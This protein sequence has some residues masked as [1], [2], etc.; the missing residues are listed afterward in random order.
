MRYSLDVY[1]ERDSL[2]EVLGRVA[3]LAAAHANQNRFDAGD[4]NDG[5]QQM[6]AP[7]LLPDGSAKIE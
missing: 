3:D 4:C 7:D 6:E 2:V 1:D 5:A